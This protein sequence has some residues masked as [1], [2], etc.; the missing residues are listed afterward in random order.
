MD[1]VNPYRDENGVPYNKFHLN[2]QQEVDLIEYAFTSRRMAEMLT[3]HILDKWQSY[4]LSHLQAIHQHLFQDMYDWAG[5]IRTVHLNKYMANGQ[6]SVFASPD[7]IQSGWTKL[8]QEIAEF[9]TQTELSFDDK[10]K[11]LTEIFIKANHLHPFAEGNGR[12]LQVFMQ[13]LARTQNVCLDYRDTHAE[14]WNR[15]CALSGVYGDLIDDEHGRH[16]IRQPTDREP[17]KRIFREI[18]YPLVWVV[19]I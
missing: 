1:K 11:K 8:A 13:Q 3:E 5:K 9:R 10:V 7:K 18:A 14:D 19:V 4:D 17:I 16:I 12:S 15:A 2:N 6:I